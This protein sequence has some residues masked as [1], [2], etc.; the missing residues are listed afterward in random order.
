MRVGKYCVRQGETN[1]AQLTPE[2]VKSVEQVIVNLKDHKNELQQSVTIL[3]M[4]IERTEK[5]ISKL[6]RLLPTENRLGQLFK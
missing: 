5:Q 6:V 2:E 1:M 3:E 4:E